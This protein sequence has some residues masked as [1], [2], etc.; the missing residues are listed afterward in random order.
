MHR[1]SFNGFGKIINT[2]GDYPDAMR[3]IAKELNVPLIDLNSM[4]KKMYEAWGDEES[5]K[6][7]C[8]YPPNT[9]PGQESELKDNTHFNNFGAY[10]IALCIVYGIKE[11]DLDINKYITYPENH[12]KPETPLLFN[13]WDFPY[14]S[15]AS[16]EKPLGS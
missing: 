8:H 9:F 3:S 13:K 5:K 10:N 2:F 1:R 11:M 7:F 6:A 14:S 4:S 16:N 12:F 15:M